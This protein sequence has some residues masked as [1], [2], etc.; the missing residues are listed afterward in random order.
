DAGEHL[1]HAV[2][3]AR[4]AL[5]PLRHGP[6]RVVVGRL[7]RDVLVEAVE[8]RVPVA[9][10]LGRPHTPV[11]VVVRL[12][13]GVVVSLTHSYPLVTDR[14]CQYATTRSAEPPPTR[15]P[16]LQPCTGRS[17]RRLQGSARG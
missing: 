6:L 2:E 11:E 14:S 1:L 5:E 3:H 9:A 7:E 17:C 4:H 13:T 10:V 8:P 15:S 16:G 12:T